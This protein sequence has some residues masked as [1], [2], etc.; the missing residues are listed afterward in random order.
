MIEGPEAQAETLL[1]AIGPFMTVGPRARG[2]PYEVDRP[3]FWCTYDVFIYIYIH[4]YTCTYT[5]KQAY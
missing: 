2:H 3:S 1:A 5:G 4:M